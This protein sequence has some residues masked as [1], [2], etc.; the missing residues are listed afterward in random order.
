LA[1]WWFWSLAH[2]LGHRWWHAEMRQGKET[3]YAHGERQH[4]KFYDSLDRTI[5]RR[6]DPDEL[7]ISFPARHVAAVAMLPVIGY[8]W[9]LGWSHAALFGVAMYS[10]LTLDHVLHKRF[11]GGRRLTGIVGWLQG[12]HMVHH[13]TH[14]YNFFF[15]SGILWDFI[16]G[17][18]AP[19]G[20][21]PAQGTSPS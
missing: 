1:G 4:H 13:Q 18:L 21:S 9:A 11:H 7:F 17:T 2:N 16:F 20:P 15:V 6:E 12:M 8:G 14:R 5:S 19:A 3:F 10:A